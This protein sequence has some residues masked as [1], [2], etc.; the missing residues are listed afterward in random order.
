MTAAE[1]PSISRHEAAKIAKQKRS[2]GMEYGDIGKLLGKLGYVSQRTGAALTQ[3]GVQRLLFPPTRSEKIRR[4]RTKTD[5]SRASGDK[6]IALIR[7]ICEAVTDSEF[8]LDL[9]REVLK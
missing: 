8:K 2:E 3:G 9:I 5:R 4:A 6:K 7:K 1:A